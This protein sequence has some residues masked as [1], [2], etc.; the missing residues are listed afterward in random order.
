MYQSRDPGNSPLRQPPM[1]GKRLVSRFHVRVPLLCQQHTV[2]PDVLAVWP[3]G[4]RDE[5]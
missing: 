5:G 2:I 1:V 3:L 4:D